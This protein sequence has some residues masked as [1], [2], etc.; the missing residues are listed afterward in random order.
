MRSIYA[1]NDSPN[2]TGGG[3]ATTPHP[4]ILKVADFLS[5]SLFKY[6]SGHW[7]LKNEICFIYKSHYLCISVRDESDVED[8]REVLPRWVQLGGDE[9][10]TA[11]TQRL[12]IQGQLDRGRLSRVITFTQHL[13]ETNAGERTWKEYIRELCAWL[14]IFTG[15]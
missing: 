1:I 9:R 12:V 13:E 6:P 10:L 15:V 14:T 4:T 3:G 7:E 5:R 2:M 11:G 8:V